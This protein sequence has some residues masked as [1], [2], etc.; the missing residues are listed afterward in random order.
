MA[1]VLPVVLI[2]LLVHPSLVFLVMS[3]AVAWGVGL[4]ASQI[5]TL[6]LVAALPS[7]SNVA[8]LTERYGANTGRIAR[9]ILWSTTGAFATFSIVAWLLGVR[10][11]G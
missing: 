7:A 4:T 11:A 2:K 3:S 6:T 5:T 10:P 8:M 1:Q 9:I